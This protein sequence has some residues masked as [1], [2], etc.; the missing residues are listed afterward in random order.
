LVSQNL[1]GGGQNFAARIIFLLLMEGQLLGV[2]L[3]S[4][5]E[6]CTVP[7]LC[8]KVSRTFSQQDQAM[9][10]D[11]KVWGA[12]PFLPCAAELKEAPCN[13]KGRRHIVCSVVAGATVFQKTLSQKFIPLAGETP[14][15]RRIR[16]VRE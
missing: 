12:R 1:S 3:R 15:L 2:Y 7:D 9:P 8:A 13:L 4:G 10:Y 6:C 14:L 11:L 16:D 5:V